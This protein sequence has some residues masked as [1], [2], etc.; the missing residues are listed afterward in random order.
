VTRQ[1]NQQAGPTPPLPS[2]RGPA[3]PIPPVLAAQRLPSLPAWPINSL[4]PNSLSAPPL[5]VS[6]PSSR[7]AQ[8]ATRRRPHPGPRHGSDV[9]S[10]TL[11]RRRLS[12]PRRHHRS[13]R[14]AL[15]QPAGTPSPSSSSSPPPKPSSA[16]T[17]RRWPR[18]PC[19]PPLHLRA[20]C[21]TAFASRRCRSRPR[22]ANGL[23]RGPSGQV[24]GG[25]GPG[26]SARRPGRV[27][28]GP[29]PGNVESASARPEPDPAR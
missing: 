9:R 22:R 24:T 1:N 20:A 19:L 26:A 29:T 16:R 13:H 11:A 15:P 28:L 3:P 17:Q 4:N 10:P 8:T 7:E 2:S 23:T 6:A 12:L 14:G 18:A 27:G 25:L 21:T 5:S